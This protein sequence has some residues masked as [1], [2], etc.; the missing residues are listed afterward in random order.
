MH[1]D[2]NHTSVENK[3]AS[4]KILKKLNTALYSDRTIKPETKPMK[5]FQFCEMCRIQNC[6]QIQ[7]QRIHTKIASRKIKSTVKGCLVEDVKVDEPDTGQSRTNKKI[8]CVQFEI[9]IRNSVY[10][11]CIK[12]NQISKME[13]GVR[14]SM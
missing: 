1:I 2:E 9:V 5:Y 7:K 4:M 10:K 13:K 8:E 6:Y 14:W 11:Y 3:T 12:T